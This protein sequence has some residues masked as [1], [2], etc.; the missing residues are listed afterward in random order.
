MSNPRIHKADE[1]NYTRW[2]MANLPTDGMQHSRVAE[3]RSENRIPDE[4]TGIIEQAR[5]DAFTKGMQDGYIVGLEKGR[6]SAEAAEKSFIEIAANFREALNTAD[7]T[8]ADDVLKLAMD[9]AK[10]MVKHEIETNHQAVISIVKHAI[11]QL[12]AIQQPAHLGLHPEDAELVRTHMSSELAEH[13][14][15]IIE[16]SS[17][18]RGGCVV[19]TATNHVDATNQMRWKLIAESLGQRD[20]WN[21]EIDQQIP[22]QEST[23]GE[24]E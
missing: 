12:P 9:I 18:Q 22:A 21:V 4:Y 14:W 11:K 20:S 23:A 8:M 16:D 17:I 1:V 13:Q 7:E 5:K 24:A 10:A 19:V 6:E 3:R 2:E 15:A